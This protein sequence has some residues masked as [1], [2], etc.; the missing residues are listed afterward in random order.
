MTV[1]LENVEVRRGRRVTCTVPRLQLDERPTLLLGPNGA[2]KTTLMNVAAGILQPSSGRVVRSG[3]T[4]YVPQKF[5]PIV[6]FSCLEYC[7]YVAWLQGQFSSAA[8]ADAPRWL[9][10]VGLAALRGHRCDR[11]SGGEAARLG[12]AT[13]LDSAADTLLLDE[14]SASLDPLSKQ[15]LTETYQ[16][17]AGRG[18][19]I[20]VSTHDAGELQA[21]FSRVLVV[22][23][24]AIAFDGNR[25]E[26]RQLGETGSGP[27]A[28]LA[29]SFVERGRGA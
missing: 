23:E 25:D 29:R 20:V 26:F 12:L 6:G 16:R 17:V 5:T 4:V 7:A 19:A 3:R 13:A 14:P 11:L 10:F 2:G 21:P 1:Y 28:V 9:D 15:Q 27:V 8:R 18:H 22:L 24:G